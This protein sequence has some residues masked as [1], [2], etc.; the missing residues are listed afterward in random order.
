MSKAYENYCIGCDHCKFT[1]WVPHHP[2]FHCS[3][4]G[5]M[6]VW[7]TETKDCPIESDKKGGKD[8]E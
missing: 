2:E 3:I 4:D 5:I 8:N 1:C 7:T 6:D